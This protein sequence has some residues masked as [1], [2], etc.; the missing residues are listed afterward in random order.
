M[1]R[2]WLAMLGLVAGI[3]QLVTAPWP[4]GVRVA[5][6]VVLGLAGLLLLAYQIGVRHGRSENGVSSARPE[7]KRAPSRTWWH[8]SDLIDAQVVKVASQSGNVA[9]CELARD[10]SLTEQWLPLSPRQARSPQETRGGHWSFGGKDLRIVVRGF[11]LLLQPNL[12]GTW[13]GFEQ[14]AN[15]SEA[16]MGAILDPEPL[17]PGTEWVGLKLGERGVRRVLAASADGHLKESD[18]FEP[19]WQWNGHW[20]VDDG[21]LQIDVE[22]RWML[23]AEQWRPGIFLGVEKS[24]EGEQGFAVIRARVRSGN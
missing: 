13:T 8:Q 7:G 4:L 20:S 21:D 22:S 2:P 1:A 3:V 6:F 19:E 10:G 12:N 14:Y 15:E 16:F 9:L 11:N 23:A 5:I 24:D 18:S 17:T